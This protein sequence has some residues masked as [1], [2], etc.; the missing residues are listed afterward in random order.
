MKKRSIISEEYFLIREEYKKYIETVGY[1][2]VSGDKY[3]FGITEFL[4]WL[5]KREIFDL[6]DVDTEVM[7][8]YYYYLSSRPKYRGKGKLGQ[9]SISDH[10][11]SIKILFDYLKEQGRNTYVFTPHTFVFVSQ[12]DREIASQEEVNI[13][14][15]HCRTI[16]EKMVVLI[17]YS[18]GARRSEMVNLNESDYC[19]VSRT[20]HIKRGKHNK[21]RLIPLSAKLSE[22]ISR[23]IHQKRVIR[24]QRKIP[25][26][27]HHPFFE[28]HL[29]ERSSGHYLYMTLKRI[30]RNTRNTPLINKN[31]SLHSLRHSV[32]THFLE[33]G[34]GIEFVRS[35]LGHASIDTSHL[36]SKK[37]RVN[38]KYSL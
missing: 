23:Y 15:D 6:R 22:E 32:A 13:L 4:I 25:A 11:L 19:P 12:K 5:E 16:K 14:L 30:I 18:C 1:N 37:R 26:N 10:M 34:A 27:C 33:N 24:I 35:F 21:S 3:S 36:Y 2:I 8:E 9:S 38:N 17:A 29:G 31:L 7:H 20:L 28:N